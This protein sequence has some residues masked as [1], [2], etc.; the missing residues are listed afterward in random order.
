MNYLNNRENNCKISGLF[1]NERNDEK[2]IR[3]LDKN[4]ETENSSFKFFFV[5][6]NFCRLFVFLFLIFLSNK[7]MFL[8]VNFLSVLINLKWLSKDCFV[9][10]GNRIDAKNVLF[11]NLTKI[12][13]H[14]KNYIFK[15]KQKSKKK[16]KRF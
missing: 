8:N 16:K 6:K 13:L 12:I 9:K 3:V 14:E 7:K 15:K 5:K 1:E 11:V 2:R 4:Y 10:K